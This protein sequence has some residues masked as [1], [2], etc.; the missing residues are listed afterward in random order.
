MKI[1]KIIIIFIT[2]IPHKVLSQSSNVYHIHAELNERDKVIELIQQMEFNYHVNYR[3]WEL[4][5]RL[6]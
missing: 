1:F 6:I 4:V 5:F 2:F 3:I